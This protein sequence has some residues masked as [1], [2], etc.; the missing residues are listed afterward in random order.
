MRM[1]AVLWIIGSLWMAF[2]VVLV[3]SLATAAASGHRLS[4]GLEENRGHELFAESYSAN[5]EWI[6]HTPVDERSQSTDD[7]MNKPVCTT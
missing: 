5:M 7:F 2:A 1:I 3:L 6:H 4:D